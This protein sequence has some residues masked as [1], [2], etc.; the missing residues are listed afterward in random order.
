MERVLS[1][2]G[3]HA[4]VKEK[5]FRIEEKVGSF[6]MLY[7]LLLAGGASHVTLFFFSFFAS[8]LPLLRKPGL[9]TSES[10]TEIHC[11]KRPTLTILKFSH[12]PLFVAFK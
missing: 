10:L 9:K 4:V 2:C 6:H 12:F 7:R 3:G 8:V 11:L 1:G 5:V